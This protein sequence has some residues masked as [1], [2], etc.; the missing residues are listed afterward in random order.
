MRG[1][2][3]TDDERQLFERLADRYAAQTICFLELLRLMIN[4]RVLD[5][6][7][8]VAA[9]ERLSGELMRDG[10]VEG[11]TLADQIRDYVAGGERKPS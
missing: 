4:N 8:V 2:F 7:E 6:Q 11:V 3:V 1:V 10:F 5:Q 9:Y